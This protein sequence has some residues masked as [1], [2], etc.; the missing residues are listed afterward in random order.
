LVASHGVQSARDIR[1]R[2]T[3]HLVGPDTTKPLPSLIDKCSCTI[4]RMDLQAE[5]EP[6]GPRFAH[7]NPNACPQVPAPINT[8]MHNECVGRIPKKGHPMKISFRPG[9]LSRKEYLHA[10]RFM[11]SMSSQDHTTNR[12]KTTCHERD[13]RSCLLMSIELRW[14]RSFVAVTDECSFRALPASQMSPPANRRRSAKLEAEIGSTLL[15][16]TN[17]MAGWRIAGAHCCPRRDWSARSAA[18]SRW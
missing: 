11:C 16:R 3:W 13:R 8:E 2:R 9:G 4:I 18:L 7:P 10:F 17:R 6:G 5:N 14:L 15:E 1:S 12:I